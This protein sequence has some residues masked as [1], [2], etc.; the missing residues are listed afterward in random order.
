MNA[1]ERDV[2][3]LG[4]SNDEIVFIY[5]RSINNSA[6]NTPETSRHQILDDIVADDGT[7]STTTTS[8]RSDN[9]VQNDQYDEPLVRNNAPPD[10]REDFCLPSHETFCRYLP[11]VLILCGKDAI[12]HIEG[13]IYGAVIG[14][15]FWYGNITAVEQAANKQWRRMRTLLAVWAWL[16]VVSLLVAFRLLGDWTWLRWF[17]IRAPLI[18]P[19]FNTSSIEAAWSAEPQL[20]VL[21]FDVLMADMQMKL[22]TV[23]A[24]LIVMALPSGCL[25]WVNR[26]SF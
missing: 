6:N 14:F 2:S 8:T 17:G 11:F 5:L 19:I 3:F 10:V 24:K 12:D 9:W 25:L 21:L 18:E 15:T 26:V 20:R 1:K 13:I 16:S 22:L 4:K 7:H 23:N